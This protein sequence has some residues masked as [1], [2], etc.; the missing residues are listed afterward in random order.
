MIESI[1][2]ENEASYTGEPQSLDDLRKFNFIFGCNGSGKT[3]I[4]RVIAEEDSYPDCEVVWKDGNKLRALVYNRDFVEKNYSQRGDLQGIF[5]L[6]EGN[7]ETEE[8]IEE[9]R[10]NLAGIEAKI[11]GLQTKLEA[12]N[13]EL[14]KVENDFENRCW[15]QKKDY[16]EI[17]KPAFKGHI[18]PATRFKDKILVES[19]NNQSDL[20]TIDYL[21]E[22]AGT[23]FSDTLQ[24]EALV[25]ELDIELIER[26]QTYEANPILKKPII[27]K[28]D[29]DIA[30]MI[31][32]L[33]N[34]DW[35]RQGVEYYEK[36]DGICPFCQQPTA[37]KFAESL[38]DYFNDAFL[39]DNQ[40]LEDLENQ[41][42]VDSRRLEQLLE[43]IFSASSSFLD[44]DRF[45]AEKRLIAQRVLYNKQQ[46]KEKRK[47]QSKPVELQSLSENIENIVDLINDANEK[48][49]EHNQ[50]F[51]NLKVKREELTGQI[52]KFLVESALKA[53]IDKYKEEKGKLVKAIASLKEKIETGESQQRE[54]QGEINKLEEGITSV[55]PTVDAINSVIADFGFRNFTLGMSD[56]ERH[57]KLVREDGSD[58]MRTLSEG[59]QSFITFLYFYNLV[60]GN[61]TE[62]DIKDDRIVVFDDPVSSLD[63]D[64]LFIVSSLIQGLMKEVREGSNIKQIFVFTHNVYFHKAVAFVKNA[65]R[66]EDRTKKEYR[67]WIV[68]KKGKVS[69]IEHYQVNPIQSSYELLW[70]ELK[71]DDPSCLSV[72]N[73]MRRILE[74]YFKILGGV[75][76][77][78]LCQKFEGEEKRICQ[79][80][81]SWVHYGSHCTDDDLY[82]SDNFSIDKY[83]NVFKEIFVRSNHG[84][85]YEM[86]TGEQLEPVEKTETN[87][88]G[89]EDSSG[90]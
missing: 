57:Y 18:K 64:V 55:K 49:Q 58:A 67:F 76:L 13:S 25:D 28:E 80:L 79:S 43:D 54:K 60:K 1:K 15:T 26:V 24:E 74:H 56:D 70:A 4:T 33:G 66:V 9:E 47:E 85:H 42:E 31:K 30:G 71:R 46:I 12:K 72:Q 88:S 86:M 20:K 53:E 21:R 52:W 40:S 3:T 51:A 8:K 7:K 87:P 84:S 35:V 6:G 45:E 38:R 69:E 63:S 27:G 2:I 89:G 90:E 81:V 5:T 77:D 75:D 48:V 44:I 41:Y 22:R 83:E 11:H 37:E 34:S 23:V 78:E 62:S 82:I 14:Q 10:D 61:L 17:F 68:R 73:C 65:K 29:V 32:S 36:N 59:E 19:E 16:D 50:T 39:E